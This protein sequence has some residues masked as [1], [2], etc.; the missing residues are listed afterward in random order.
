MAVRTRVRA[1]RGAGEPKG[2]CWFTNTWETC[3]NDCIKQGGDSWKCLDDC[4]KVDGAITCYLGGLT[5]YKKTGML[6][7]K[8]RLPEQDN[9]PGNLTRNGLGRLDGLK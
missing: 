8:K 6:S 7:R 1:G 5:L 3:Y 2:I 4:K 9:Q